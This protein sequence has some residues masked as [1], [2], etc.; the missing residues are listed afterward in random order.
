MNEKIKELA[1]QADAHADKLGLGGAEWCDAQLAKFAEL[2]VRECA[3]ADFRF[4]VGLSG[5]QCYDVSNVILEHFDISP[6]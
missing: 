4:K 5:E 6:W 2:I 3:N 1:K